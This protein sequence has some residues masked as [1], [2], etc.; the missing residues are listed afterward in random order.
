MFSI[1]FQ[2]ET[3]SME[4]GTRQGRCCE[5]VDMA[6]SPNFRP[7]ISNLN[8]IKKINGNMNKG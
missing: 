1:V 6:S 4:V 7:R 3:G 5:Q 2:S 8:L